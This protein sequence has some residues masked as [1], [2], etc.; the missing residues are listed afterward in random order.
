MYIFFDF[1]F[2]ALC[3][4][5]TGVLSSCF[6]LFSPLLLDQLVPATVPIYYE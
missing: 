1:F 4:L 3:S 2:L 6:H 5:V